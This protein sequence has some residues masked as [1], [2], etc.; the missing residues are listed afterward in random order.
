MIAHYH[1]HLGGVVHDIAGGQIATLNWGSRNAS[2][3]DLASLP[4]SPPAGDFS[5][6][7]SVVRNPSFYADYQDCKF[8]GRPAIYDSRPTMICSGVTTLAN[9]C[10]IGGL[11]IVDVASM[12]PLSEVP[13]VLESDLGT[14]ITQNPFDVDVVDGKMRVYFMPDQHNST[15]YIYEAEENSPFQFGGGSGKAEL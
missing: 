10:T 7:I 11:A 9:N 1:D 8:L 12:V 15:I 14:Q 13:L 3:W 5:T 6:P 2:L 4:T